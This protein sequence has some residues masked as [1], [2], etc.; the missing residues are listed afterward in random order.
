MQSPIRRRARAIAI[1]V[2]IV[3]LGLAL[4][5]L[6]RRGKDDGPEARG[7]KAAARAHAK[8]HGAR[9]GTSSI[10][11]PRGR[12][13][14]SL[15]LTGRVVTLEDE[16]VPGATV[17]LSGAANRS[18]IS[19]EGGGFVFGGLAE[20]SYFAE[21]WTETAAASPKRVRLDRDTPP[22]TLRVYGA[23]G[24]LVQ[25]LALEDSHPIA[26]A[27]VDILPPT[28]QGD[29]P[30]RSGTT[31][32]SGE[33]RF[34]GLAPGSYFV[35]A[36]AEGRVA[37]YGPLQPQAGLSWKA[38]L[39][40]AAG[41][42]V[43]GKVVDGSGA[44]IEGA[45]ISPMPASLQGAYAARVPRAAKNVARSNARGEFTVTVAEGEFILRV[46]HA[47]YLSADSDTLKSDG[48]TPISGVT[49]VL[50][51]G[52]SVA[53]QVVDA[54][55]VAQPG[56]VVR[57]NASEVTTPGALF[58][59]TRADARGHF[60][61]AGLPLAPIEIVAA[62]QNASSNNEE[63]DLAETP[64]VKDA[65][66]RLA[67]DGVIRGVVTDSEGNPIADAEVV[68]VGRMIGAIG[69]RPVIPETTD[70]RGRFACT[71]LV[72]GDYHLTARRPYPKNNQS[73][74]MR[75]TGMQA[76]TGEDVTL[77]LPGDGGI[78][79]QVRHADRS[80]ATEVEVSVD[81]G[82]TPRH[83]HVPDG[84]FVLDGLAPR[85]YTL[86]VSSGDES[87]ETDVVVAEGGLTDVGVLVLAKP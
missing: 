24:L 32:D 29:D 23:A 5:F 73:P 41:A 19:D 61:F 52:G 9:D 13:L 3:A 71:G 64:E 47:K 39:K 28:Q 43:R 21:A 62:T 37:S 83:F 20:G 8:T 76:A 60:E 75:S 49:I 70:E 79:G 4:F 48:A 31:D 51:R 81:E 16:P 6:L 58:R 55:G 67:Y 38:T 22:I 33:I 78:V 30:L 10:P 57:V 87:L 85:R 68:C 82:G 59:E 15:S 74:W 50:D 2:V 80:L 26:G 25:V 46:M 34:K 63:F 45:F 69:V 53:G 36:A 35:V 54:D 1:L 86:H 40:L 42:V 65:L 44:P 14:E 18:A 17:H 12:A 7:Q 77:V 84:R 66:I 27:S 56:A 11:V 72:P